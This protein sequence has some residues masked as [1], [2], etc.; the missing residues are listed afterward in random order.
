M[1]APVP[2]AC[3]NIQNEIADLN[4]QLNQLIVLL[5][6]TTVPELLRPRMLITLQ[7]LRAQ[8]GAQEAS[9][10]HCIQNPALYALTLAGVEV[11]QAIQDML[12]S[13]PLFANKKTVIRVYF[14]YAG[15]QPITVSGNLNVTGHSGS[16]GSANQLTLDPTD[17]GSLS[18]KRNDVSKSLNFVIPPALTGVGTINI[19]LAGSYRF[20]YGP[21]GFPQ[22]YRRLP[23]QCYVPTNGTD[24]R[25]GS[26]NAVPERLATRHLQSFKLGPESPRVLVVARL[27]DLGAQ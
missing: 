19:S 9:L 17:T 27:S 26:S 22:Q 1:P 6:G 24:A 3:V 16:I 13:V 12:G 23:R 8:I 2:L 14:N 4:K 10:N 7:E 5:S 11:T 20:E 21:G 18:D 25:A 15:S